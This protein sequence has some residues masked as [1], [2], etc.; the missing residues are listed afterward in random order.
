[1]ASQGPRRTSPKGTKNQVVRASPTLPPRTA[2]ARGAQAR[3]G[4]STAASGPKAS[5]SQKAGAGQGAAHTRP[6][7]S[8]GPAAGKP[9]TAPAVPATGF[10]RILQA[11]WTPVTAL[12]AVRLIIWLLSLFGLGASTWLTITHFDTKIVLAC[13]DTGIINCAKVTTS[14]QSEVFGV[15]PVA[16]LGLVFYVFMAVVNSPWFWRLTYRWQPQVQRMAARVRLGSVIV[17]MC[18]V[19]YLVWA[20]LIKI[21]N[22]C[23]WCTSV[24]VTTFLIFALLVFY[25]AFSGNKDDYGTDLTA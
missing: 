15:I 18:F 9:V 25:T 22:I 6:G 11:I 19:L 21:G 5:T 10:R 3:S 16:V 2:P 4:G 7:R 20:E 23:L 17:G 12:G 14:P 8:G 1:M 24:H 13:P